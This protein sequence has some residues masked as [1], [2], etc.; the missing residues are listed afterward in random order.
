MLKQMRKLFFLFLF[1][2]YTITPGLGIAADYSVPRVIDFSVTG[3]LLPENTALTV[4]LPDQI[5][6]QSLKEVIRDTITSQ[7]LSNTPFYAVSLK[8]AFGSDI[9]D[10]DA[11]KSTKI[12]DCTVEIN[13]TNLSLV[14]DPS[15]S[16]IHLNVYN[17]PPTFLMGDSYSNHICLIIRDDHQPKIFLVTQIADTQI[18]GKANISFPHH[19]QCFQEFKYFLKDAD[20]ESTDFTNYK[21]LRIFNFFKQAVA[22]WTQQYPRYT[23]KEN[24]KEVT[25]EN[26]LS[27]K[28]SITSRAL[29]S[30]WFKDKMT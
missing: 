25:V 20:F 24:N 21:T 12:K 13:K 10:N 28:D 22:L 16:S 29:W 15:A 8:D 11:I 19:Y 6:P 4:Q 7:K 2:A 17:L 3:D 26:A 1:I 14:P 23:F 18:S 9:L 30:Y 5:T 27:W